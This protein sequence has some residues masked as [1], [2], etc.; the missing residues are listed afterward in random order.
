MPF[1][2]FPRKNV[3]PKRIESTGRSA[4]AGP[5]FAAVAP[6]DLVTA[7]IDGG[8]RGNPGPAGFGV[9]LTDAGGKVLAEISEYLGSS[10]NN[11]AEYS[12]LLAALEYARDHGCGSLRV[13][14]DSELLVRQMQGAYKV[15]SPDLKP[16][17]ER[18]RQLARGLG[19]FEIQHVPRE[20]NRDADRLANA[21]MDR[22]MGV[23][24]RASKPGPDYDG[25]VRGGV[26]ELEGVEL[27]EGTRVKVRVVRS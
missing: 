2:T 16:L 12:A 9:R 26:V 17:H 10:T 4:G 6:A 21:A 1:R 13:M 5:L 20:K 25:R 27:A 24:P 23:V 22:G 11:Q 8:A 14:S 18:A 19:H 3:G 15:K 7:Y